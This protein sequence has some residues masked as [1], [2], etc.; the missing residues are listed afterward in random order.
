MQYNTTFT[1]KEGHLRD[2]DKAS[3]VKMSVTQDESMDNNGTI[4]IEFDKQAMTLS[5]GIDVD[6]NLLSLFKKGNA[7]IVFDKKEDISGFLLSINQFYNHVR[8]VISN[9]VT[10]NE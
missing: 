10:Y 7:T 6:R 5:V 4:N 1:N 9:S 3:V 8:A 2:L